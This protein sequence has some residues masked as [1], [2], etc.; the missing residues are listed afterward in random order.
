MSWSEKQ[1][2]LVENIMLWSENTFVGM[3]VEDTSALL[4]SNGN[5]D[6]AVCP[7]GAYTHTLLNIQHTAKINL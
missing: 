7:L 2:I 3:D 6:Q 4:H 5:V 1:H